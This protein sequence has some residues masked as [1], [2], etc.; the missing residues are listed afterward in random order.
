MSGSVLTSLPQEEAIQFVKAS[1][2][3]TV[4]M[5]ALDCGFPTKINRLI[6]QELGREIET[7]SKSESIIIAIFKS[8]DLTPRDF[9]DDE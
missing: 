2:S 4:Y 5:I 7:R 9:E 6:L 1:P 8:P 3:D